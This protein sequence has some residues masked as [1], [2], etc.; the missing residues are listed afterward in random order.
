MEPML[1]PGRVFS[2]LVSLR[3]THKCA[4]LF[5]LSCILHALGN[6]IIIPLCLPLTC[7][8][9]S[10]VLV[11][12]CCCCCSYNM[13]FRFL[14]FNA[15]WAIFK[16]GLCK[17]SHGISFTLHSFYNWEAGGYQLS[18]VVVYVVVFVRLLQLVNPMAYKVPLCVCVSSLYWGT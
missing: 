1:N 13:W 5:Q 9:F 11:C 17:N 3:E 14:G 18:F 10:T 2:S 8:P 7:T 6:W 12:C 15:Q 4:N 16:L